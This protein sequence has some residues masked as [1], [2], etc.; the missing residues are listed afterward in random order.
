MLHSSNIAVTNY[1]Q[2]MILFE[3]KE[4]NII[5]KFATPFSLMSNGANKINY[6]I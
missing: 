4:T 2:M 6:N 1:Y 3:M 5:A